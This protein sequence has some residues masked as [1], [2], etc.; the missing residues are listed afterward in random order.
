MRNYATAAIEILNPTFE[1]IEKR[2][3]AL[4]EGIEY[5]EQRPKRKY[6]VIKKG[7]EV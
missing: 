5:T 6:G 4:K 2:L 7:I 3:K 1:E